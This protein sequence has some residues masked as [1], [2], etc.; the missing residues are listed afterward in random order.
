[1]KKLILVLLLLLPVAAHAQLRPGAFTT[2][3]TT[4]TTID[5]VHIG[6]AVGSSTCTGG[7]KAGKAI[8]GTGI[9]VTGAASPPSAG[10]TVGTGTPSDTTNTIYNVAGALWFNGVALSTGASVVG[11]PGTIAVFTGVSSVGDSIITEA[12]GAIT[13]GGAASV[14]GNFGV[15]GATTLSSTLGVAG[16][17]TFTNTGLHLLDTNASHDL[18]IVPGSDLTADRN[19]T[20]VTGDAARTVTLSGN[21]TLSDWFDQS[22]KVAASPVFAGVTV[23]PGTSAITARVPSSLYTSVTS[24][25]NSGAGETTL[26]TQAVA[27]NT[28]AA[29]GDM[30]IWYMHGVGDSGADSKTL[31][32]KY[33]GATIGTRSDSTNFGDWSAT[34]YIIR[35]GATA[36]SITTVINVS[37]STT[38]THSTGTATLSGAVTFAVTGQGA[39]SDQVTIKDV[40]SLWLPAG[41]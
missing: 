15:S 37:G 2:V 13:V 18:V 22:V 8:F 36:Q 29:S 14:T 16:I 30:V 27:A 25:G 12:A 41:N 38:T 5:S 9:T 35:T 1:M 11:T 34:A 7:L 26:Y 33:N 40:T 39:S 19:L 17:A 31:N 24:T 21:P 3:T 20:F 32:I 10:I 23:T 28:L 6:C 4:N